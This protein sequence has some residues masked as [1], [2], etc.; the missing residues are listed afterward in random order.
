MAKAGRS[1]IMIEML[2][3]KLTS[4]WWLEDYDKQCADRIGIVAR[5]I[6]NAIYDLP[7]IWTGFMS[8][9]LLDECH[10]QKRALKGTPEHFRSRQQ[11]GVIILDYFAARRNNPP[12]LKQFSHLLSVQRQIHK[13]TDAENQALTPYQKDG[14]P[15]PEAYRAV[16]IDL[17]YIDMTGRKAVTYKYLRENYSFPRFANLDFVECVLG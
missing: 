13:T 12:T 9:A 2:H 15:W 1:E 14:W 7:N 3:K 11:S 4:Y 17:V 16:G 8:M 5:I 6:S 10:R